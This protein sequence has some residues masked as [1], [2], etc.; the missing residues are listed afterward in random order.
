MNLSKSN[1]IVFRISLAAAV[2]GILILATTPLSY[3]VI[4]GIN[5]KL[6]HIFAF[7]VLSLLANLSFPEKKFFS[8]IFLPLLGYGLTIEIIQHFL[9]Y[10][11]FS[12]FDVAADALGIVLYKIS[13][14]FLRKGVDR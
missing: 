3:P 12:L 11:I 10:R 13:F 7:F 5:D 2:S 8:A 14:P 4:S 1:I 6:N 9:P